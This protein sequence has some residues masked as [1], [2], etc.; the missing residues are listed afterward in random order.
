M[1]THLHVHT[2]YSLLD[3]LCR[4]DDLVARA[5]Q[6]GMNSIAITDHGAMYGVIQFY[7]AAREASIKP[8]L[9]CELYV[10]PR[11]RQQKEAADKG[12]Y[13]LTV[14]AKNETGYRNITELNSRAHLEGFYYRPRV[15]RELLEQYRD[16]VI[17]LSGCLQGEIP[18]LLLEGREEEA[19]EA[20]L[21][22]K[23]TFDD[24]YIEIQRHPISELD[25]V[26]PQLIALAREFDIPL[27]ATSDVHYTTKEDFR[28]HD[29]LLC[30]QRNTTIYD[31]NRYSMGETF[32]LTGEAEMREL[33][34]DIPDAVDNTQRVADMCN[35]E[36]EFGRQLL[37]EIELPTGVTP[38]DYLA[39]LCREGLKKRYGEP[40]QEII[41]RLEYELYVIRETNFANYFLVVGDL[42]SFARGRNILVGVRGSAAASIVLYTLGITD[43]DPIEHKLVFERFL[44]VERREMPDIDLDF[45]DDRRD[46][47]ITYA[48]QKWGAECVAQIITFGTFGA[49]AAVRD[50]GRALGMSYG[51]VDRVARLIPPMPN[52]TLD[53]ALEEN[54]ELAQLYGDDEAVR[55]LVDDAKRL[56]GIARH[57][58]THAAGIVISKEPLTKYV[59]LQRP[60]RTDEG[61]IAMT[62]FSMDDIARIGLLKMD[63]LGLINLTVLSKT[64]DLIRRN[65]GIDIDLKNIPL[66]DARTFDLLSAGETTGVFQLEGTGMRAF[67]KELKPSTFSDIAA[68][69]ALYRPGPMQ[70]IPRF[71]KSKQGLEPIKFPHETL[72]NILRDTYGIIVYQDQV[73]LIVQA[74]AGYSLGAADIFRKAMGKKIPEVMKKER[75]NFIAGAKEKGFTKKLAN[76]VFDLI[77][78]FAGYAFNKAHSTSYAMIAYQTA[79]FKANYPVEFMCSLM[80][81]HMGQ[82]EKIHSAVG[83]CNRMGIAVLPPDINKSFVEFSIEKDDG[84]DAIRFGLGAIKNVGA[85]AVEPVLAV[86]SE[87]G[88]F[89]SIAEFCRR[90][91]LRALNKRTLES[92]IK[93]GALDSFGVRGAL[94]ANIDRILSLAQH[95]KRLQESGQTTMFDLFGDSVQTPLPDLDVEGEDAPLQE[96]LSWERELLGLYLSEHPFTRAAKRLA[97]MHTTLCGQ[98]DESLVGKSVTV[99]GMVSTARHLFTRDGKPF[100]SVTLEDLNGSIDVNAWPEVYQRTK[101]LWEEGNILLV[102]G[103][104]QSRRDQIQVSVDNARLYLPEEEPPPPPP[105]R[106]VWIDISQSADGDADVDLLRSI[107]G[108]VGRFPGRDEVRLRVTEASGVNTL[109]LPGA[110]YTPEL[111]QRLVEI[112]GEGNVAA[113]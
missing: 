77:E 38:D 72:E 75:E 9:G 93:V 30:V 49:R 31:D 91:D 100:A 3:G 82:S 104:V 108:V 10:A 25:K 22:Y 19:R 23:G 90:T 47:V 103:R 66:D 71:I 95:E 27:V 85:G 67:V 92:L 60:A 62:Q 96:K 54:P 102:D 51:D 11:G 109:R 24:F 88:E 1:F 35:V 84:G 2:E 59:P 68:M 29:L 48:A 76:E 73:L 105:R 53:S 97:A 112:V 21:W 86:R 98:I 58:S 46:E 83:D 14:L 81:M 17:A 57:A 80:A 40:S 70:H 107:F 63:I 36:L 41:D 87:G 26:N 7:R 74:F 61:A 78:P 18:R 28:A 20:A 69:I 110:S 43:I 52:V 32:Y 39:G 37:P 44:N 113:G 15:D 4:I 56:E 106:I 16:G 99:A 34:A 64:V 79:Y 94:L 111:H 12:M 45:Q 5:K 6:L 33:Y 101:E 65:R 89:G 8:V 42:V 13:H 55:M 50:V